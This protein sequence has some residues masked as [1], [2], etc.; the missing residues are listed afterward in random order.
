MRPFPNDL[1]KLASELALAR[2]EYQA[3]LVLDNAEGLIAQ[4]MALINV[5]DAKARFDVELQKYMEA[6]RR[7]R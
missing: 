6:C 5:G 2:K 1:K 7:G 3:S 4:E